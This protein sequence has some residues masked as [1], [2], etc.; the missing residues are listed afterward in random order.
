MTEETKT[1][2]ACGKDLPSTEEHFYK[3]SRAKSGLSSWCKTCT[4]IKKR[5]YT[6]A[7]SDKHLDVIAVD[8]AGHTTMYDRLKADAVTDFRSLNQQVLWIINDYFNRLP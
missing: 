4:R 8:F 7:G 1:C 2:S 6:A 3:D 5:A